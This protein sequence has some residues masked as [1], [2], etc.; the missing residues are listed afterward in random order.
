MSAMI[1]LDVQSRRKKND[2]PES[3]HPFRILLL[4]DFGCETAKPVFVDR[5]NIN[6]LPGKLGVHLDLPAGRIEFKEMDDFRP[7]QL[8]RGFRMFRDL[9]EARKRLEDPQTFRKV[10]AEPVQAPASILSSGSLLDQIAAETEGRPA[11]DADPFQQYLKKLV[12]PYLVDRPNPKQLEI[13]AKI[14]TAIGNEMRNLLHRPAFQG[15]EAAWRAVE[16]MVRDVET[17]PDLKIYLFSLPRTS[18]EK[19]LLETADLRTTALYKILVEQTVRTPGAHPWAAVAGDYSFGD[20]ALDI[21]ILGRIALLA[22]AAGTPFFAGGTPDVNAWKQP[23]AEW[24]E[25][26]GIPEASYLGVTLPRFLL[27]LPYGAKT[28]TVETFEFEEIPGKPEHGD[29]LWGNSAYLCAYLLAQTFSEQGWQMEP[30]EILD[31]NGLPLHVYKEG[32]E[33][34][35]KPC[36][37]VLMLQTTCEDLMEKGLMPVVSMKDSD[38]VRLAGFRAINGKKIAGRWN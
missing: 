37:E 14:E 17:N 9:Q 16:M 33:A 13:V 15:L 34:V 21:E 6:G 31:V 23:S 12:S 18:L 25:L 26:T 27:R 10:T 29:Y 3:E 30:G 32:G 22:G 7:E 36:A 24:K 19:D 4:G 28:D 1:E 8:Y 38:R 11:G 5:D 35:T 2:G 20:N